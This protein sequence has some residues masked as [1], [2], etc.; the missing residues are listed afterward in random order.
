RRTGLKSRS[1]QLLGLRFGWVV[2]VVWFEVGEFFSSLS[3][4][5]FP[6]SILRPSSPYPPTHVV[7]LADPHVPHPRL[8]YAP[9]SNPWMNML[10]QAM[11]ELFMRKSWNVVMRLGRVD[12]VLVLGDMLDWGRGVMSDQDYDDYVSLF[13]S[14]F[15]LPTSTPM[16][17]VPG[18]HDVPLGP[19]PLFSPLARDRYSKHFSPPNAIL[20]IANHSLILLDAVGL[21]E[22]D[23]RRY[24]AEMQF[25]EWDGVGG[26]VIEFVKALGEERTLGETGDPNGLIGPAILISHIPLA[27][28]EKADCGSLRER[29]R[30]A[31][32]AG[33]GYQN[34]LGSETT[35]FLLDVIKPSV[36][37]SG[38]DH[39]YCEYTHPPGIREVTVKSF[40]SSTGIRRPGFQLLSLVPPPLSPSPSSSTT[41][42]LTHADRPCFL[43]DQ[44]GVYNR[45]YLPLAIATCLWLLFTNLR[46]AW[47][48]SSG[49]S[50]IYSELKSRLSPNMSNSDQM[51]NSATLSRG[52]ISDRPVP[53]TLPSRK[54]S[55][56]LLGMTSMTSLSPLNSTL[57]K[58]ARSGSFGLSVE[59]PSRTPSRSAPVSP[60]AS[61][62]LSYDDS[63]DDEESCL[64]STTS[65]YGYGGHTNSGHGGSDTPSLSRR[66]SYIYMHSL[67]E[68]EREGGGGG[69]GGGSYF[70]PI[71]T[72]LGL[73]T[74]NSHPQT[75]RRVSS[76][77]SRNG[78]SQQNQSQSYSNQNQPSDHSH[79]HSQNL[80]YPQPNPQE[81]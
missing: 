1:T 15:R 42:T 40:S 38:D 14:I 78:Q 12:V 75:I 72:G 20:P 66:S 2:L 36:V 71:P 7:L 73:S 46:S 21:V 10:R 9:D 56:H 32:G 61:P 22:E 35:R 13:R 29:G 48:R 34:L 44:L 26:G 52:R 23:Y 28:P 4:C 51:P 50:S 68:K 49:L 69:G 67:S 18:N 57:P 47:K 41:T 24:A 62:R 5:K 25:G 74:P 60:S 59:T 81:E 54:S 11:D 8:S 79:P 58:S 77:L 27:R 3:S 80:I 31:K 45:V 19:N 43:P 70:L 76:N 39:D 65:G 55:Q 33:P 53:L 16:F 30:I 63:K 6:D 64:G 17:F 37:F